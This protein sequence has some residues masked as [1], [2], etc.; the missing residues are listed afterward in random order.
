MSVVNELL[1][2]LGQYSFSY[3]GFYG[4]KTFS[5]ERN[6]M[7]QKGFDMVQFF[8]P[9]YRIVDGSLRSKIQKFA[10]KALRFFKSM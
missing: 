10:E 2:F 3:H 1:L 7:E 5:H 9:P 6:I 4:F 8:H